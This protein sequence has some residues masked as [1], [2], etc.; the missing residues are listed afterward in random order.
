MILPALL[1]LAQA[2][3]TMT[4]QIQT[5][6]LPIPR[7]SRP[8]P[9]QPIAPPVR[10]TSSR[11]QDCLALAASDPAAALTLADGWAQTVKG[12]PAADPAHCRGVALGAQ[13]NW[14]AAEQA[15]GAARDF[16]RLSQ[17]RAR[18]GAMAGNAAL[19]AGDAVRADAAF[20]GAYADARSAADP[21]LA[22]DIAI[23]RSRALIALHRESEA[24]TALSEART[25][26]A[27]N[28]T[29]WL[30]SATLARR[31]GQLG[32]AQQWIERAASLTP[33]DP[34]VGLEAGIIAVLAG[35]EAAARKSWQSVV[36]LA[37]DSPEAKTA[38]AYLDQLGPAS[39]LR[40]Q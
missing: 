2:A 38:K 17:A 18:Y 16:A 28:A 32:Q 25:A 27:D 37:P 22:G 8:A 26:S 10:V 9:A 20:A 13:G 7:K 1:L 19:A 40:G 11:L 4:P 34:A 29:G 36:A 21:Q 5:A 14:S 15:F 30:L 35:R 23:D 33:A 31:Q 6:P 12:A 24:V 39:P 3:P